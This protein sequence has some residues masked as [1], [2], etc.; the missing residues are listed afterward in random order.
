MAMIG[1]VV[2]EADETV[3]R[4]GQRQGILDTEK[5]ANLPAGSRLNSDLF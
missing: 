4:L 1:V 2:E 5:M 3:F